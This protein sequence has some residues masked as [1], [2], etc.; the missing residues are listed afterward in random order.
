MV[1][2]LL[3][4][5]FQAAPL[6][7]LDVV[8]AG[9]RGSGACTLL[10]PQARRFL[11]FQHERR[12]VRIKPRLH[13]TPSLTQ[14]KQLSKSL[15]RCHRQRSSAIRQATPPHCK[16]RGNCSEPRSSKPAV[17][18]QRN[19]GPP[20]STSLLGDK[21]SSSTDPMK[22]VRNQS[23]LVTSTEL[24]CK[25]V[26]FIEVWLKTIFKVPIRSIVGARCSNVESKNS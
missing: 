21:P 15:L 23:N 22:V 18:V 5:D 12:G 1:V 25:M 9:H 16:Q 17:T 8:V 14:P 10:R 7:R 2:T 11:H 20:C 26:Q 24:C 4:E 13:H 3:V 19:M 6:H